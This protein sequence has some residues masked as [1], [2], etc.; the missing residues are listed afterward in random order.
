MSNISTRLSADNSNYR[1]V[2][3]DSVKVAER[4]GKGMAKGLDVT[5]AMR[6]IAAAVGLNITNIAQNV[7]RA[8]VGMSA[9]A[10]ES[11]KRLATLS[12][13]V[14]NAQAA[15]MR[16]RRTDEQELARLLSERERINARIDGSKNSPDYQQAELSWH[17][18][19]KLQL[20]ML[21]GRDL[22]G[23]ARGE[24]WNQRR[25]D[26]EKQVKL[27]YELDAQIAALQQRMESK[28]LSP[29]SPNPLK[30]QPVVTPTKDPKPTD[31]DAAAAAALSEE[32][33]KILAALEAQAKA[34]DKMRGDAEALRMTE[35]ARADIIFA[36]TGGKLGAGDVRAAS[37]EALAEIQRRLQNEIMLI[38]AT[39]SAYDPVN[40]LSTFFGNLSRENDLTKV[41]AELDLRRTIERNVD[42]H[43]IEGAR[44]RFDGDPLSFDRLV[45]EFATAKTVFSETNKLLREMN[46]R[47]RSGLTVRA[48]GP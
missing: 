12:T 3:D 20:G 2:M 9:E 44:R 38:K 15:A 34:M 17:A 32:Q 36:M 45:A 14:A 31:D 13:E 43:G 41:R 42:R 6:T 22:G 4:A 19:A 47:Q 33:Q 7:A 46:E 1:S 21:L 18:R 10:E 25:E 48:L 29:P 16:G 8:V 24:E 11:L 35:Q 40:Q 28:P 39:P 5:N 30:A 26:L 23:A 27:A 37:T